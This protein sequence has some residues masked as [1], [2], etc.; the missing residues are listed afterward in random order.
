MPKPVDSST[1]TN[2]LL[3]G[4]WRF[5]PDSEDL[6]EPWK[7]TLPGSMECP[8][9]ASYNDIFVNP[10]LRNHVG[11]VWYQRIC[12]LPRGWDQD[13]T[14][15]RFDAATHAA[16]VYID[17]EHVT[18][19]VGGYTPFQADI[20]GKVYPGR[21]FRITVSVD[22]TLTNET[23]PPGKVITTGNGKPSQTYYHDFFNYSGLSRSVRL[24]SVPKTRVEDITLITGLEGST[25]TVIYDVATHGDAKTVQVE[26]LDVDH[27][28]VASGKGLKG[29]LKV[30]DANLWGPGTPYLYTLRVRLLDGST[31]V[32]EYTLSV[33]IRTV[34]V[35]GLQILING[36]PFQFK[37]FGRHEDIP[38]QAKGHND[39]WMVHDFELMKWCGANSFRTSHYPYAEDVMDYADRQGFLVIDETPAVGLNLNI[40]GG[41]FGAGRKPTFSKEFANDN[42]QKAHESAIRELIQRD[43]NH[44]CVIAWSITNECGSD[45]DGAREYFEPLVKVARQLDPTR[46]LTYANCLTSPWDKDRIGDLFDFIGIN[47][48]YGWYQNNADLASAEIALEKDLQGWQS[49]FKCPLLIM[50]YGADTMA[51]L[52]AMEGLPWSEEYQSDLLTMSHRVFDKI[53]AI[54]GEHVWNFADFQTGPG[55]IRVDGNK[56]G[57]FTRDRRPKMAA[58]TLRK[59]W[60]EGRQ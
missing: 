57:V 8:V 15:L 6:H 53:E 38:I 11:K 34:E 47:R 40:V 37:G 25:G 55:I 19:H 27:K 7:T 24:C 44:P 30:S 60:T 28:A 51:G 22:N 39:A 12:H 58:H 56:K 16:E 13:D 5:V 36:K 43:K 59:R 31:I 52:H 17:D 32:D 49:R 1:R 23:I 18:S 29:E 50:E 3:D 33:G 42:T 41:L 54:V 26:L 4:L 9:P 48:Y 46:P 21:S 2:I 14:I 35:K 20:S 10:S 45:E